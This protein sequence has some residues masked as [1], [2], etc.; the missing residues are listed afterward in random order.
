MVE[1]A[2]IDKQAHAANP[3]GEIGELRA[4][5]LA[6]QAA[7]EFQR[8]HPDTLILVASDHGHAGQI[9]PYPSLFEAVGKAQGVAQH[10][11]GK[12]ARVITP[13]GGEMAVTYGTNKNFVEEHTGTSVPFFAIGPGSES[14]RGLMD[15]RQVFDVM[16]E[17][18]G[19]GVSARPSP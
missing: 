13:E 5:D 4:L 3:C 9:V 7:L 6:V 2:S 14:V 12:F 10:P 11:A 18:A 15:Q 8:A 17:A 1:S 19:F 16:R